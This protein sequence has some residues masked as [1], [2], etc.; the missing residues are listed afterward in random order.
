MQKK[1]EITG[2]KQRGMNG[3]T[4]RAPSRRRAGCRLRIRQEAG[5]SAIV[6]DV[7]KGYKLHSRMSLTTAIPFCN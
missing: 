7:L 1:R 2:G 3:S 5:I 4:V 6:V